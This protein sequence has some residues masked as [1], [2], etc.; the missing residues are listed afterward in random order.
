MALTKATYS[1]I[2]GAPINVQ[3]YGAVGDGVTD[4]TAAVQ[5]AITATPTDGVV[6]FPEGTYLIN[7]AIDADVKTVIL[8]GKLTGTG[9]ITGNNILSAMYHADPVSIP[10]VFGSA[11]LAPSQ[12]RSIGETNHADSRFTT[13][14][15][16]KTFGSGSNGPSRADGALFCEVIKDN[17]LTSTEQG[18][19]D[20]QYIVV[21]QGSSGDAGGL[22]IDIRKVKDSGGAVGVEIA[23]QW[24]N[25]SG[26]PLMHMKTI[27]NFAEGVGGHS[28]NTGYG[29]YTQTDIG[30]PFSAYHANGTVG[31]ASWQNFLTFYSDTLDRSGELVYK[32]DG[33]GRTYAPD[34]TAALPS[35]SF[36]NDT[37]TG[38]YRVAENAIGITTNGTLKWLIDELGD[39]YPG[40]D[41]DY[42][43][44]TGT[45]RT[46]VIYSATGT[47]NTSDANEK[48]EI[49]DFSEAEKRVAL[50]LKSKMKR[51]KFKDATVKKGENARYHF[52]AIAQEVKAAFEA[53][54]LIAEEYGVFCSDTLENGS[55]RLGVRYDELFSFIVGAM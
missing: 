21:R 52:G 26:T 28:G 42:S 12:Y 19:I 39:F 33:N 14:I 23:N 13:A 53:E 55:V 36:G 54:G 40:V 38:F 16:K 5:A 24:I 29:F 31:A 35:Y 32:V 41:N 44:G 18:E 27:T 43:V 17:Y 10:T 49:V 22:L 47:I 2:E 50:R 11:F 48:T 1:M 4:D 8:Y 6:V 37:N 34:G 51:F 46:S 7:S 20:G 15:T 3:D 30:T 25:S 45:N 9:S